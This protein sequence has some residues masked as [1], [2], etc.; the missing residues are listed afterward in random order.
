MYKLTTKLYF[1]CATININ[2]TTKLKRAPKTTSNL[3]K[4]CTQNM[5]RLKL[6]T[7]KPQAGAKKTPKKFSVRPNLVVYNFT[8]MFSFVNPGKYYNSPGKRQP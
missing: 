8:A 2:S 7:Q 4:V 3:S 6:K 5:T 1:A